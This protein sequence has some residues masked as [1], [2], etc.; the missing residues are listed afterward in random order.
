MI[1]PSSG[2][3]LLCLVG[4]MEALSEEMRCRYGNK[5][6]KS[7]IKFTTIYPIMVNTGLVKNP[8]NRLV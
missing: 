4:L 5:N 6:L 3:Y 8:R 2:N 1:F 7:R